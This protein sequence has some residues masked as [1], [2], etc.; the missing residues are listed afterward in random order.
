MN[1]IFVIILAVIVISVVFVAIIA[2]VI[3]KSF[4][5]IFTFGKVCDTPSKEYWIASDPQGWGADEPNEPECSKDK[6]S[7]RIE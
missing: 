2:S 4:T 1:L 3:G 7:T 6:C 5:C